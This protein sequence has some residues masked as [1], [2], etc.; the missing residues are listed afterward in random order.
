[1]SRTL[2]PPC[3]RLVAVGGLG[4]GAWQREGGCGV[5]DIIMPLMPVICRQSRRRGGRGRRVTPAHPRARPGPALVPALTC[6]Y[7]LSAPGPVTANHGLNR[8]SEGPTRRP[9]R[10][11][12]RGR[13]AALLTEAEFARLQGL[14]YAVGSGARDAATT[15][16]IPSLWRPTT[17]Q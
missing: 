16:Q 2:S 4:G 8:R 14:L 11:R 13:Q 6:V 7:F 12:G 3:R 10:G 5:S 15:R 17:I 9:S 1:M